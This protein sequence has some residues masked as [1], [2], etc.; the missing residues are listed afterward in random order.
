MAISMMLGSKVIL[1]TLTGVPGLAKLAVIAWLVL[2][3]IALLRAERK[4]IPKMTWW[5]S[6]W[7]K[8]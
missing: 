6:R 7:G 4:D 1:S 3:S 5:L 8:R 2:G